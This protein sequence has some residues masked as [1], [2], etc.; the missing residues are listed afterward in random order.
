MGGGISLTS[1]D[2]PMGD[3]SIVVELDQLRED[4]D[5]NDTIGL[6]L[7]SHPPTLRH[8]VMV[9]EEAWRI[10]KFALAFKSL[11]DVLDREPPS[12]STASTGTLLTLT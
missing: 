8:F 11:E 4:D 9:I 12:C 2:V 3:E 1:F 7:E 10:G 6:I 5:F